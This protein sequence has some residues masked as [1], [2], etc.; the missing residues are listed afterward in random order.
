MYKIILII[1]LFL[2]CNACFAQTYAATPENDYSDL[3]KKI[4][5]QLTA[6]N[7]CLLNNSC[8]SKISIEFWVNAKGKVSKIKSKLK[9]EKCYNIDKISS[10]IAATKWKVAC[11]NGK[12][13]KQKVKVPI[14]ICISR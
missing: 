4:R 11:K 7:D 8:D 10:I 12:F 1:V 9:C 3:Y 6:N 2:F 13:V 5:E 14:M